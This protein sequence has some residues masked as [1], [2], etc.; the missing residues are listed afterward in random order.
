MAE[1][2]AEADRDLGEQEADHHQV[3]HARDRLE[4]AGRDPPR[5]QHREPHRGE[6]RGATPTASTA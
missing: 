6:H 1:G 5:Q 4:T 2:D 3:E